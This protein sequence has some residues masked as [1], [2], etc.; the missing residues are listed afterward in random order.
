VKALDFLSR[1]RTKVLGLTQATVGALVAQIP[2]YPALLDAKHA[3]YV[4]IGLGVSTSV[5]GFINTQVINTQITNAVNAA[6]TP[7]P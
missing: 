6:T 5:L 7:P 1:H 4:M 3:G 2:Q